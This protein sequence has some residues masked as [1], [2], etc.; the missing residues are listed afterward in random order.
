LNLD[1]DATVQR[2]L[3]DAG[4]QTG[5]SGKFLNHWPLERT[6]PRFDRWAIF[7][8]PGPGRAYYDVPFNTD[9]NVRTIGGYSTNYIS[10]Q[11]V[12]ILDHFE[13][14]DERPWLLYVAPYAP[15]FPLTPLPADAH[16]PVG[17]W[18][19]NAAV[20]E[21]DRSDKP[22]YVRGQFYPLRDGR[23]LRARQLRVL[24][25]VDRLV[26]GLMKRLADLDE[27]RDTLAL[28]VSDNG[29]LWGEHGL[30][31]KNLPY[32]PS[33]EIPFYVRWPG[34]VA[35]GVVNRELITNT[36][37]APTML[38][39][40]G[41]PKSLRSSMDGRPFIDG[42]QRRRVHLESWRGSAEESALWW[43]STRTKRYQ[44]VEYYARGSGTL[45]F[46]ELYDLR[47]DRWQLTNLLGDDDTGNDPGADFL[48]RLHRRLA[49]DLRC[50]GS[51]CP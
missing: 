8:P 32:T 31:G 19:G 18:R 49:R 45:E 20:S 21:A 7:S 5:I 1:Q 15:H 50:E 33:I 39:L 48:R 4:Y 2:Y 22:P 43:A 46:R 9:G 26:D 10:H 27:D 37:I 11:A 40:A 3:R 36:D 44:Y 23:R 42:M 14:Q 13:K 29:Y 12:R 34:R 51:A 38:D 24:P 30:T 47:A 28:Y 6:P 41:L 17:R 35:R 25:P 16:A